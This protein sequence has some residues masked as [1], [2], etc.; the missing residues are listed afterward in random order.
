M[1]KQE[2]KK[3]EEKKVMYTKSAV[4]QSK[5]FVRDKDA[6]AGLLQAGKTYTL[7]EVTDIL[8]QFQKKERK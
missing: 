3:T 4:L 5:R 1:E 6:L 7:Q 2:S 8:K